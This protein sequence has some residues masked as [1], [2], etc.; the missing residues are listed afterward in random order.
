MSLSTI[1]CSNVDII[2]IDTGIDGSHP[3][4]TDDNNNK[5]LVEFDWKQL[6]AFD[7]GLSAIVVH[8]Q[9]YQFGDPEG[10][11]TACASL[12]A[13]KRCGFGRNA[14]LYDLCSSKFWR[15]S[16]G[17]LLKVDNGIC[18]RFALA[19]LKAK[20]QN[21]FGLNNSR[22]TIISNS[23]S[24][25]TL[26]L[27]HNSITT[28]PNNIVDSNHKIIQAHWNF[29]KHSILAQQAEISTQNTIYDNYT[30]QILLEGGHFT[31][32]AGNLNSYLDT[33]FSPLTW[34]RLVSTDGKEQRLVAAVNTPEQNQM[35]SSKTTLISA[36]KHTGEFL[37]KYYYAGLITTRLYASPSIGF[38]E[39]NNIPYDKNLYPIIIVGDI[40][41]IGHAQFDISKY[42]KSSFDA[43]CGYYGLKN[44]TSKKGIEFNNVRY[45][46]TKNNIGMSPVFIKSSYSSFGPDVTIYAP[47]NSTWCAHSNQSEDINGTPHYTHSN[48]GMYRHF[49][50][51]SA[52]TP[53]VTGILAT[54]LACYPQSTPLQAKNWLTSNAVKG[55]ILQTKETYTTVNFITG[56]T[57]QNSTITM[58]ETQDINLPHGSEE[59][60]VTNVLK[61]YQ[62]GEVTT[63]QF[64][65]LYR[66]F[67][68]PNLIAQAYPLREAVK[69]STTNQLTIANTV[70][71]FEK[72]TPERATH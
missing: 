13:G 67:N 44:N 20:K 19:F 35:F 31:K 22:P 68:S 62:K 53:I 38:D 2:I 33:N 11:G 27:L 34:R 26:T 66:F 54:Y 72:F 37:Q 9:Y 36:F 30:R 40:C 10:H 48:G 18:L 42:T 51:T 5:L 69:E 39:A 28:K 57:E 21:L 59:R 7:D 47:G 23:W 17:Q 25:S 49:D 16:R 43:Q 32:S 6:K 1:D 55:N 56:F 14:K 65:F 8:S 15:E 60:G 63:N 4:L 45:Y 58:P 12:A 3:D 70:L 24:S 71:T 29:G 46:E 50:G 41:P 64:L 52:A 61:T